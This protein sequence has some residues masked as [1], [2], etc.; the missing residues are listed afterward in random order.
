MNKRYVTKVKLNTNPKTR[1]MNA[2]ANTTTTTAAV[3]HHN[4]V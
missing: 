2:A 1:K 3:G 4:A